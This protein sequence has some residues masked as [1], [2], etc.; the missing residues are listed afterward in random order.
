MKSWMAEPSR[1]NSGFDTTWAWCLVFLFCSTLDTMSPVS[2]GTVD[3]LTTTSE[4]VMW[5]AIEE[6]AASTCDRSASPPSPSGVLTAMI[7]YSEPGTAPA[8]ESG[9]RGS[10]LSVSRCRG[11]TKSRY[12]THIQEVP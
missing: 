7:A 3:L 9:E 10:H 12:A 2:G 4:P 5:S 8:Y 1:R 11:T 6:A